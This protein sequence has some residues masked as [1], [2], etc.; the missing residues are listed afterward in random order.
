MLAH[1]ICLLSV[2]LAFAQQSSTPQHLTY[3]APDGWTP[4]APAS[5]MRVAEFVLPRVEGD[6]EDGDTIIFFFGGLG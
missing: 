5:S 2:L 1:A 4:R 6:A 3:K